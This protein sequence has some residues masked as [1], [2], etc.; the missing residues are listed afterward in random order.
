MQ[1]YFPTSC[2]CNDNND[3]VLTGT[4][5]PAH[6]IVRPRKVAPLIGK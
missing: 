3:L 6:A 2:N 5:G 4:K 1:I